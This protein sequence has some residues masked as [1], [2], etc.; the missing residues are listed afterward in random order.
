MDFQ[1]EFFVD[2]G[3]H[4]KNKLELVDVYDRFHLENVSIELAKATALYWGRF[5]DAREVEPLEVIRRAG[6]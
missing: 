2:L 3:P 4:M 1:P 5:A 6:G